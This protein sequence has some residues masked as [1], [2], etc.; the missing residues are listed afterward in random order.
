MLSFFDIAIHMQSKNWDFYVGKIVDTSL[1]SNPLFGC[2][3]RLDSSQSIKYLASSLSLLFSH[4]LT[5]N[6]F[7]QTYV[8]KNWTVRS[9]SQQKLIVQI[10]FDDYFPVDVMFLEPMSH[11]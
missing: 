8:Q 6:P 5:T 11:H 3:T 4:N 9:C 2:S 10:C 1:L 7:F